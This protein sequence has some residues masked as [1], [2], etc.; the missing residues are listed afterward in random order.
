MGCHIG[1]K[2]AEGRKAN[3]SSTCDRIELKVHKAQHPKAP[4]SL[5]RHLRHFQGTCLLTYFPPLKAPPSTSS[6]STSLRTHLP[7]HL[8]LK[9]PARNLP[10]TSQAPKQTSWGIRRY[11]PGDS[12]WSMPR[13]RNKN[14]ALESTDKR[15]DETPPRAYQETKGK[16]VADK[17]VTSVMP[18][19]EE[20]KAGGH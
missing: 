5:P 6:Q 20:P 14:Q 7:R 4:P 11:P 12:A 2:S 9:A 8:P 1:S 10:G 15:N 18:L 16:Q 3:G 19:S 17:C 13:P